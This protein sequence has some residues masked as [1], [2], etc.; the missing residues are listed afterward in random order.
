MSSRPRNRLFN[1]IILGFGLAVAGPALGQAPAATQPTTKPAEPVDPKVDQILTRLEKQKV[2]DLHAKLFWK[3]QYA[4]DEAEEASIKLGEIWFRQ[5]AP[6]GRFL[7]HFEEKLASGRKDV[8]DE[9][10]YFDGEWYTEINSRTKTCVRRQIRRPEDRTDP[11]RVGGAFPLPF[12]QKKEDILRD[13]TVALRPPSSKDPENTDR[14]RLTPRPGTPV[15][16]DYMRLDFW[17]QKGGRLDGLPVK[18][19]AAK[20]K[21]DGRLDSYLTIQFRDPELNRNI[22]KS[23]FEAKCPAGYVQEEHPLEDAAPDPVKPR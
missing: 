15:A 3:R 23:R 19:E 14:V 5:G 16:E 11:Y 17:V 6:V 10:H 18:V 2:R 4:I 20:K 13:F 21:G 12:G 8:I 1:A 7:I 9:R 22:D